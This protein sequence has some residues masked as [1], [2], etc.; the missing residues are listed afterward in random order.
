MYRTVEQ[1]AGGFDLSAVPTAWRVAGIVL[2]Q[3]ALLTAL[4]FYFGW[5]RSRETYGYFGVDVELLGFSASDYLLRS[6]N[7]AFRPLMVIGIV[8][9]VLTLLHGR[10]PR[11]LA[12]V[13]LAIGALA[14]AVGLT[15]F[16]VADVA[17]VLGIGLPVCLAAGFFLLAYA[18]LEREADRSPAAQLR[19]FLL[20]GLAVLG[21]FWSVSLYALEVGRERAE[22][23][24]RHLRTR[25]HVVVYSEQR[26]SLAGPGVQRVVQPPGSRYRHRYSGLRLLAES[27][28]HFIL[29]PEGWVKGR[30]AAM[31]IPDS[32]DI[33]LDFHA[34]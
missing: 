28:G 18:D 31:T 11:R 32:E 30:D 24:H 12:P 27:E 16:A 8:A 21:V 22:F 6:V 33:R 20:L 19:T 5:A 3:T 25:T 29:L 14:V 15:G 9:V 34:L 17:R 13:L 7:S 1:R 4:L 26:L 2:S 23:L 10:A